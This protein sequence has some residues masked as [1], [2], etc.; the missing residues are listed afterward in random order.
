[1]GVGG[2]NNSNGKS[3]WISWRSFYPIRGIADKCRQA[4]ASKK[5]Q[6]NPSQEVAKPCPLFHGGWLMPSIKFLIIE[7][8]LNYAFQREQRKSK[9]EK[10]CLVLPQ[11]VT[12][13][14]QF[15]VFDCRLTY[16][17]TLLLVTLEPWFVASFLSGASQAFNANS[18]N[19]PALIKLQM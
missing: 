4:L 18:K 8:S 16:L 12:I 15:V 2:D 9:S 3:I 13:P 5:G 11:M 7:Q 14:G 10:Y 6:E 1:M 17:P 19:N